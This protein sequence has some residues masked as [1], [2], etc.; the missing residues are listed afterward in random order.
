[1]PAQ[2]PFIF[3]PNAFTTETLPVPRAHG[4]WVDSQD[5]VYLALTGAMSVD[6]YVKR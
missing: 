1:M 5:N 2:S 6:K 3:S 4:L